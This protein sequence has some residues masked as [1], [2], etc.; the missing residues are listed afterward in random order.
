MENQSPT[1]EQTVNGKEPAKQEVTSVTGDPVAQ[2]KYLTLAEVEKL[3]IL[4]ALNVM[5]GNK[6]KAAQA[7]G[8][9]IKT[10]YNKLHQYGEFEN[11]ATRAKPT[12]DGQ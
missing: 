7:L 2:Q 6:T 10:L 8:I 1:L 12:A 9:T 4:N 5:K 3:Y 11:Y